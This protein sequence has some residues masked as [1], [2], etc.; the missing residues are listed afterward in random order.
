[1]GIN[2]KRWECRDEC[3]AT[4]MTPMKA[5]DLIIKCYFEA[6]RERFSREQKSL[7]DKKANDDELHKSAA[8][9][10]KVVFK[11]MG[12]DFENPTKFYLDQAAQSF[13]KKAAA[14]GTPADI[15]AHQKVQLTKIMESLG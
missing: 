2:F 8:A 12:G 1:M 5:R 7:S 6:Q 11:E 10:V 9:A 15:I 4:G 3:E 13:A 14:W